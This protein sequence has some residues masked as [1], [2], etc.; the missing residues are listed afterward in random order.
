[1]IQQNIA[2]TMNIHFHL[3]PKTYRTNS[4]INVITEILRFKHFSL[5][6]EYPNGI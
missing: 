4:T 6:N 5:D 3:D 1:M 2:S